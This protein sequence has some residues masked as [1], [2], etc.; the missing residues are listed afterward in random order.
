MHVSH[1]RRETGLGRADAVAKSVACNI[2]SQIGRQSVIP[3][4][5]IIDVAGR[6]T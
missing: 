6:K 2:A 1:S 3:S 5:P 4:R